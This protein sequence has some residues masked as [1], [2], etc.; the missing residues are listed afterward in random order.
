MPVPMQMCALANK[1]IL[2]KRVLSGS[3]YFIVCISCYIFAAPAIRIA[4]PLKKV[5][6]IDV[7][8]LFKIFFALIGKL[9]R[10]KN[11]KILF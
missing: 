5:T 10:S 2:V 1:K 3:C 9:F 4:Q 7:V 6:V 8:R 11:N